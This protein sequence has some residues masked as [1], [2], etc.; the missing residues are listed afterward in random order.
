[1]IALPVEREGIFLAPRPRQP[2]KAPPRGDDPTEDLH[3]D[4]GRE[5]DAMFAQ[6][7]ANMLFGLAFALGARLD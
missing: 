2:G 5:L 3:F 7:R 4:F 6:Y 1:M